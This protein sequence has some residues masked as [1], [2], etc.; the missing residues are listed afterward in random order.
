VGEAPGD[1]GQLATA[2]LR[3]IVPSLQVFGGDLSIST[4]ADYGQVRTNQE[5][6]PVDPTNG[7]NMRS[8]WGYGLGLSLGRE[9]NF[10]LRMSVAWS[11][12]KEVPQSDPRDRDPRVYAQ[13]IK[14]F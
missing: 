7:Q 6:P 13:A 1:S 10:L 5:V 12:D 11:G 3:Y 2:E 14:W 8:I 4:F 9:G